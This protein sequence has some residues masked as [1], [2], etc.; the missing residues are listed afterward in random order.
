MITRREFEDI[1][2]EKYELKEL[3]DFGKNVI[4]PKCYCTSLLEFELVAG[5]SDII[6]KD[7]TPLPPEAPYVITEKGIRYLEYIRQRRFIEIRRFIL[8]QIIPFLT[9]LVSIATLVSS[10]NPTG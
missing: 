3:R 8:N 9:L 2:L 5:S 6:S 10:C 1:S 4:L 7:G